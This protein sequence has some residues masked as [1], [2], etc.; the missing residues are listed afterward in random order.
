MVLRD[1][2]TELLNSVRFRRCLGALAAFA[3]TGS[4]FAPDAAEASATHVVVSG[5]TL[6][7]IASANGISTETLAAWNG[8]SADT[9]VISGNSISVPSLD[10]LG[11]TGSTTTTTSTAGSHT[12]VPGESLSSVAAANGVSIADLAAA[13]G[14]S[15]TSFLIE[16]TTIQ[17][18][19]ASA[20][21]AAPDVALGSIYSPG[22][23]LY[24]ES[25]AAS[26]WN[27]MRQAS[28]SQYGVDIYPG[29][30]L[31][32][33]RTPEQ[34]AELYQAYPRRDRCSRE[35]AGHLDPPTWALRRRPDRG[36]AIGR[37]LDRLAVRLGQVRGLQRVVAPL[38]RRTASGQVERLGG[39]AAEQAD[40][41][42]APWVRQ[43]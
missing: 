37:R 39:L 15:S 3:V 18:P 40:D 26:R 25:S 21:P 34:Q 5:E 22:G 6:S 13:N 19:A 2:A 42:G 20:L 8:I 36:D 17:I 27:E 43:Q 11:A 16:G 24:L 14:L 7:G 29:G 31:S 12:V 4:V 38:L 28:I 41:L 10:D 35:P 9:Y 33:Y 1:P 30:S 23:D 32:A